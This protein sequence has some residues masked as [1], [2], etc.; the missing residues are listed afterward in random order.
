VAEDYIRSLPDERYVTLAVDERLD[1]SIDTRLLCLGIRFDNQTSKPLTFRTDTAGPLQLLQPGV[2]VRNFPHGIFRF[3]VVNEDPDTEPG[4]LYMEFSEDEFPQQPDVIPFKNALLANNQA[5]ISTFDITDLVTIVS[6]GAG[7]RFRILGY[8]VL[9]AY[10]LAD[11][12]GNGTQQ[13]QARIESVGSGLSSIGLIWSNVRTVTTSTEK[14]HGQVITPWVDLG[15]PG[16]TFGPGSDVQIMVGH[17]T[18]GVAPTNLR[19]TAVGEVWGILEPVS[20]S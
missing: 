5:E 17:Q 16:Y 8:R 7:E 6:V 13:F 14:Y 1:M 19:A 3:Y 18:L 9:M 15:E 11:G 20:I 10:S 4:Q 2:T 12:A